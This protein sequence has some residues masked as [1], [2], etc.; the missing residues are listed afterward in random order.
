[1]SCASGCTALPP[2]S[3]CL[4]EV[5]GVHR[6]PRGAAP[7]LAGQA[8]ARVHRRHRLARGRLRQERGV[9]PRPSRQRACCRATRSSRRRISTSP[10]TRSKAAGCSTARSGSAR[11]S[12]TLHCLN[13][14]LG[15]FERGRQWQIRAL[16]ER[17]RATVPDDAPLIIAGDFNDWRHK[18]NRLLVDELGVVRGVRER[19]RAPGA[20]V[21]VGDA[22]VPPRSHLRARP[23][24]R[25]CA[26]PLRVSLRAGSPTTRRSPRRS[27]RSARRA[28]NRFLPGN[29]ITLLRSGGEYFPALV[30]AIDRRRAR[31]LARDVHL[32]RRRR[33]RASSPAALV[34]AA[35][36][37]VVVRVLVDGWGARHYLTASIERD[38][39]GRRRAPAQVP[40]RGRA[41]AVSHASAAAA[42]PQALPRRRQDRVR[43][44][45]QHHRRREHA[46]TEAAARRFRAAHR[47]S[48]ARR[49]SCA[50]CSACGRS[51]SSSSSSRARCRC[52]PCRAARSGW[53]RRRRSS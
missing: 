17:I 30:A 27:T 20:H 41:V 49:R 36:R 47:G 6:G 48:A 1:M 38:A 13:V 3:C 26:R 44:R 43:R 19:A 10:R 40:A 2:T 18:A 31:S 11:A 25:R 29:R 42:A 7:R 52:F 50:R 4:Q 9:A 24:D 8:A 53:A 35:Q 28:M 37:G 51:T 22:G 5:V 32:R 12:P 21:S 45:H 16:C 34:R 39:D 33:R 23:L 46:G 14:H 15:L